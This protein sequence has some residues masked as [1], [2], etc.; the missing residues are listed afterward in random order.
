MLV[1]AMRAR[2]RCPRAS[3]CLRRRSQRAAARASS[4]APRSSRSS[5]AAS[6]R[7]PPMTSARAWA[8]SRCGLSAPE[9]LLQ[10]RQ[11]TRAA[12]GGFGRAPKRNLLVGPRRRLQLASHCL[13][14]LASRRRHAGAVPLRDVAGSDHQPAR[15]R[16][17]ARRQ[18]PRARHLQNRLL[19]CGPCG[20]WH[21]DYKLHST[22]ALRCGLGRQAAGG[23]L[24]CGPPRQHTS[25]QHN[26]P[27]SHTHA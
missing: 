12:P 18:R 7:G 26:R 20:G 6:R 11:G 27:T 14:V 15:P 3:R 24:A 22:A 9:P 25:V 17:A 16:A 13:Y 21:L 19:H 2:R 10:C 4:R 23:R 8:S 5:R 1:A